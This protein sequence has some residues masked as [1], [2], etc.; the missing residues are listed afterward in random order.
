MPF[1]GR[2]NNRIRK[3]WKGHKI[4]GNRNDFMAFLCT[5]LIMEKVFEEIN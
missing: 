3:I 1:K 4:P 5:L 2:R